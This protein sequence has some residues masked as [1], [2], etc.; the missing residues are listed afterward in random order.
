MQGQ[1]IPLPLPC[2]KCGA[3]ANGKPVNKNFSWHPPALYLVALVG[4][5]IYVIVAMIVRKSMRLTVPLCAQHAQRRSVA[6]TLS[7]VIPLVS[8]ADAFIL[9]NFGVD[10]GIVAL[11]SVVMVLTGI[12]IWAIVDYPIRPKSIDRYQGVFTGFC[13]A[14]L[15]QFSP[16]RPQ[17]LP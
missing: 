3:P 7:W 17:S 5:L 1:V 12:V 14:Y 16:A 15:Q 10:G 11:I 4:L 8:I 2:V 13:E 9:P 6:V